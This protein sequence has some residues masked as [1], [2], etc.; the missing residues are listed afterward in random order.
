MCCNV[1]KN[2][3][4]KKERLQFTVSEVQT[5][6]WFVGSKLGG[7]Q[8]AWVGSKWGIHVPTVTCNLSGLLYPNQQCLQSGLNN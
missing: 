7:V 5:Y 2:G 8:T 3:V 1:S 4:S 6:L